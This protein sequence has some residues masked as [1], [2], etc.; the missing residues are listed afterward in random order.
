MAWTNVL[1]KETLP[2][3]P[4]EAMFF[5]PTGN[6][7]KPPNSK[8]F[9]NA[10][11]HWME[12][13][14]FVQE[15]INKR[16]IMTDKYRDAQIQRG[17]QK[18]EAE[19]SQR[20]SHAPRQVAVKAMEKVLDPYI[21]FM[22]NW[23]D[24]KTLEEANKEWENLTHRIMMMV[25]TA[26]NNL[27]PT[28][29]EAYRSRGLNGFLHWKGKEYQ[30]L[31]KEKL[32]DTMGDAEP[33]KRTPPKKRDYMAERRANI[34]A[35][36]KG[37]VVK[38]QRPDYPD[39]DGDG[40]TD[41]PMVDAIKTVKE[42]KERDAAKKGEVNIMTWKEVLKAKCIGHRRANKQGRKDCDKQ[43]KFEQGNLCDDCLEEDLDYVSLNTP[44]PE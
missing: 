34:N 39:I 9:E 16:Y 20:A 35:Q 31:M 42:V 23:G 17:Q 40:D 6:I 24:K 13:V 43:G 29:A 38:R 4:T 26:L 15:E 32:P 12:S 11:V 41:E 25:H 21:E 14:K 30:N 37:D 8:Y 19:R 44:N 5:N 36:K 22:A 27:F 10:K 2:L 18:K 7:G 3:I 28:I 33:A 1:K